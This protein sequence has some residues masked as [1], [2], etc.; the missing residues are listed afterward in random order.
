MVNKQHGRGGQPRPTRGSQTSPSRSAW[1]ATPGPMRTHTTKHT[2]RKQ[3]R[4]CED[5]VAPYVPLRR[6]W[7]SG[8]GHEVT[9]RPLPAPLHG[10][11][12]QW[13][14]I[15]HS[16]PLS[17]QAMGRRGRGEPYMR[18]AKRKRPMWKGSR[19]DSS[20][21][22]TFWKRLNYGDDRWIS[23]CQGLTGREG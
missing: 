19:L 20:L 6:C 22:Q 9:R 11:S 23:G 5:T 21:S 14:T 13:N 2:F 12:A 1:T 7:W 3:C 15:W 16:K 4:V 18:N 17:S 8:K 10:T